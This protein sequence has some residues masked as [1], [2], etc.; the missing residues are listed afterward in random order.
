MNILPPSFDFKGNK[1]IAKSLKAQALQFYNFEVNKAEKEGL[2]FIKRHKVLPDGSS[3]SFTS[4]KESNYNNRSGRVIVT[5]PFTGTVTQDNPTSPYIQCVPSGTKSTVFSYNSINEINGKESNTETTFKKRL[6]NT[7]VAIADPIYTSAEYIEAPKYPVVTEICTNRKYS[8]TDEIINFTGLSSPGLSRKLLGVSGSIFYK[9]KKYKS[10]IGTVV[11]DVAVKGSYLYAI[12]GENSLNGDLSFIK[13]NI[14][15][16]KED[17]DNFITSD[18]TILKADVYTNN[19]GVT[20]TYNNTSSFYNVPG[21]YFYFRLVDAKINLNLN[22]ISILGQRATYGTGIYQYS[23]DDFN[24]VDIKVALNEDKTVSTISYDTFLSEKVEYETSTTFSGTSTPPI[25]TA[26]SG[27]IIATLNDYVEWDSIGGGYARAI[28]YKVE[29]H[30]VTRDSSVTRDTSYTSLDSYVRCGYYYE[31]NKNSPDYGLRKWIYYGIRGGETITF[32]EN[33][34]SNTNM[35]FYTK[36]LIGY[37]YTVIE[38]LPAPS[39]IVLSDWA[40]D[41]ALITTPLCQEINCTK[42]Y[43]HTGILCPGFYVGVDFNSAILLSYGDSNR[44]RVSSLNSYNYTFHREYVPKRITTSI[45]GF[46]TQ[47]NYSARISSLVTPDPFL[48]NDFVLRDSNVVSTL[49]DP[50]NKIGISHFANRYYSHYVSEPLSTYG[51]GSKLKIYGLEY[52]Y[53]YKD[54]I[55]ILLKKNI[56]SIVKEESAAYELPYMIFNFI[57]TNVNFTNTNSY[58]GSLWRYIDDYYGSGLVFKVSPTSMFISSI[59]NGNP[60]SNSLGPYGDMNNLLNTQNI[61]QLRSNNLQELQQEIISV[62]TDSG[63]VDINSS[64]VGG[65]TTFCGM[66]H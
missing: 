59:P 26:S 64:A 22:E 27:D 52:I 53:T 25:T 13:I 60:Y 12:V 18:H 15:S 34:T 5:S 55:E 65:K 33:D 46:A 11:F 29:L 63:I 23:V 61:A 47:E 32:T 58:R 28:T 21:T 9:N 24:S 40:L 31:Y 43:T 42:A 45:S 56:G 10:N 39:N 2:P 37:N 49:L 44:K 41:I 6:K 57:Y 4:K 62:S 66:A 38:N 30:K 20:L 7:H 14:D 1:E 54:G 16:A 50:Y 8:D 36:S 48:N 17:E 19:H 35:Y 51:T 3:I